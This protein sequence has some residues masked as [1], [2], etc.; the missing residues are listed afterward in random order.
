MNDSL[1]AR[2]THSGGAVALAGAGLAFAAALILLG[3]D[4]PRR[5]DALTATPRPMT[6]HRRDKEI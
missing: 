5:G 6:A 1:M 3:A 2:G 4:R